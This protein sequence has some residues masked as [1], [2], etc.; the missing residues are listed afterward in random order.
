VEGIFYAA[1]FNVSDKI[2][3]QS[4]KMTDIEK[5]QYAAV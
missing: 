1:N 3:S 4:K 5:Y 2:Y